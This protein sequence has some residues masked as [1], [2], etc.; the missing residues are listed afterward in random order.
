MKHH[1]P[2]IS[3]VTPSFNQ[4]VFLEECIKSVIT[5]GYV[6]FEYIIIDGGSTDN[7]LEIIKKYEKHIATWI[8]APDNGQ[9]GAI[10]KGFKMATGE[11]VGW[12]NSDDFYLPGAL[13]EVA[14]AYS[15]N[16]K[17][18]FYYGN[19]YRVDRDGK[20]INEF[21]E[22]GTVRFLLDSF[23]MGLN[24]ILQPVSFINRGCLETI[25]FLDEKLHY[26]M[27]SDLWIRLAKQADPEP[28][29]ACLAASRE[30]GE[31]K[32]SQGSFERVE[33]LRKIAEKHSGCPMTPGVLLYF[34]DTLHRFVGEEGGPFPK[35]FQSDVEAFWAKAGCGLKSLGVGPDGIP[36]R[37]VKK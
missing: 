31:T 7:S 17:A 30:Y 22:N 16:P 32:T 1:V 26:G 13:N 28:I 10:N 12:L 25:G 33:E 3:I 35:D 8:S 2:R 29:L 6:D 24:Y 4:G 36:L 19:G 18:S 21:Y 11:I 27:D 37:T 5:Q 20:M 14:K 9:A 23:I 15:A 34:L